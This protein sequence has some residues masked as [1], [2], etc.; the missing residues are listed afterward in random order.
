M[1]AE[2]KENLKDIQKIN[3]SVILDNPVVVTQDKIVV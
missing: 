2:I 3:N 1:F